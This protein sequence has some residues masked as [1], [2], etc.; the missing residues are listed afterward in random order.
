MTRWVAEFP[1]RRPASP[2]TNVLGDR[3]SRFAAQDSVLKY[4]LKLHI[5]GCIVH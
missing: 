2:V 3:G 4:P 1:I 5:R